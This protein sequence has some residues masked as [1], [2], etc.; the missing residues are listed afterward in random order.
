MVSEGRRVVLQ[1]PSGDECIGRG[2]HANEGVL[3]GAL[4]QFGIPA[5]GNGETAKIGKVQL[6]GLEGGDDGVNLFS[7]VFQLGQASLILDVGFDPLVDASLRSCDWSA[8]LQ[9]RSISAD[10]I[11]M[12]WIRGDSRRW[13]SLL[14]FRCSG[15]EMRVQSASRARRSWRGDEWFGFVH[16]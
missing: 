2:Q 11:V 4:G 8:V 10:Y 6:V 3:G 14:R 1:K 15:F 13:S 7:D 16:A 12:K 9:Y 5:P